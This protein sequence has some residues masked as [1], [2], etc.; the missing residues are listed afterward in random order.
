ML[1][2]YRLR[3]KNN[4]KSVLEKNSKFESNPE[5]VEK[6]VEVQPYDGVVFKKDVSIW[7]IAKIED[8]F[9]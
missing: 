6:A 9:R 4:N 1:S 5:K 8:N 2:N 7:Q 3:Q